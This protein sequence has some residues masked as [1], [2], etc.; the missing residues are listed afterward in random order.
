VAGLFDHFLGMAQHAYNRV[1]GTAIQAA[2]KELTIRYVAPT[3]LDTPLTFHAWL[4][5]VDERRVR[6]HGTCHAGDVLTATAVGEFTKVSVDR[7]LSTEAGGFAARQP[8][9]S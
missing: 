3:P 5:E 6:C 2:T 9:Q 1:R 8:R 4:E 7:I